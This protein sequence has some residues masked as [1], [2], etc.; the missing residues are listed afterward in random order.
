MYIILSKP[1]T[2]P[3]A[4]KIFNAKEFLN[5]VTYLG[6]NGNDPNNKYLKVNQ[7]TQECSRTLES[8][9]IRL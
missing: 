2:L 3:M 7:K 9:R 1:N 8:S 5:I 4:R 6:K